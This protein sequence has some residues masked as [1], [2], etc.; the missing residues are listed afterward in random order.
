MT[1]SLARAIHTHNTHAHVRNTNTQEIR[2]RGDALQQEQARIVA[3]AHAIAGLQTELEAEKNRQKDIKHSISFS[4]GDVLGSSGVVD[5]CGWDPT[6]ASRNW[7]SP[8]STSSGA[9][10]RSV[11]F[12]KGWGGAL[13]ESVLL[14]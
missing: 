3:Q 2:A 7:V 11:S 12:V 14:I 13:L 4:A 6:A 1:L 10:Y 5:F 9:D 8:Y